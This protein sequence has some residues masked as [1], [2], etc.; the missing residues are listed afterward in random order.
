VQ[1]RLKDHDSESAYE[2]VGLA[3]TNGLALARLISQNLTNNSPFDSLQVAQAIH[4]SG[5]AVALSPGE[6][7]V[8]SARLRALDL[9]SNL[10]D[11]FFQ[12]YTA[13]FPQDPHVQWTHGSFLEKSGRLE[14]AVGAYT[15]AIELSESG[16]GHSEAVQR[17]YI[18]ARSKCFRRLNR[19]EEAAAD[20]LKALGIP[21]RTSGTKPELIDL[22]LAYNGNLAWYSTVAPR[23]PAPGVHNLGGIDFDVRGLVR[24]YGKA[25]PTN[26]AGI[27]ISRPC[28]K[29]HFLQ[30]AIGGTNDVGLQVGRYVVHYRDGR[31]KEIPLVFGVELG[32]LYIEAK[33][34]AK[35]PVV[36]S[37]GD[38]GLQ[39]FHLAWDNPLPDAELRSIDLVS[40]NTAASPVLVALTIE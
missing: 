20:N 35:T 24:V 19:L 7:D 6:P 8:W 25:Y 16:L 30:A 34:T 33:V 23:F 32:G 36:W 26:I 27:G 3:P 31:Q 38:H 21:P 39:L 13:R 17:F 5:L 40:N 2:L 10:N 11:T 14:E 4:L 22:S 37:G 18:S 12:E 29:L 15:K 28:R 1:H 9:S